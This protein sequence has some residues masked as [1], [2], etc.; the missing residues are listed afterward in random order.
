MI[1]DFIIEHIPA[2]V[3]GKIV[4]VGFAAGFFIFFAAILVGCTAFALWLRDEMRE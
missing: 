1:M 3:V 2:S 4:W